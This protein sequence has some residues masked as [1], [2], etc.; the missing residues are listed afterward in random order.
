MQVRKVL[1]VDAA[2]AGEVVDDLDSIC[3][4]AFSGTTTTALVD[5]L[6]PAGTGLGGKV[7][8]LRHPISVDDYLAD[9]D[10]THDFDE[11]M[12]AEGLRSVLAVPI[13]AGHRFLGVLYAATRRLVGFTAEQVDSVDRIAQGC[14]RALDVARQ[15][16]E[17]SDIAVEKERRRL[18][19]ALHDSVGAM[20]FG[21][22]AASRRLAKLTE[23]APDQPGAEI[24]A[25]IELQ[26]SLAAATMRRSLEDMAR[27]PDRLGLGVALNADCRA[28]ERRTGAAATVLLLDD[29][30]RLRPRHVEVLRDVVR[31]A[32]VN[33]EKHSQA[34]SVVITLR[35]ERDGVAMAVADDGVGVR[36]APAGGRGLGLD[37]IAERLA[38]VGGTVKVT[39]GD[40]GG[41][42]M[43]VWLPC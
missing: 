10:I 25:F 31:E 28:F 11:A 7:A 17:L 5:L 19:V 34:R 42:T 21:I 38:V 32:L 18:A 13:M 26:A 27:P 23:A 40:E 3:L 43:R 15:A 14:G 37:A 6:I 8:V 12:R 36:H 2:F 4:R 30:P 20:L 22:T 35:R 16:Q 9:P 29:V 24:V 39:D 33:I 1:E 41:C